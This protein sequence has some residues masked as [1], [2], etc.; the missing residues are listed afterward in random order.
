MLAQAGRSESSAIPKDYNKLCVFI[1]ENKNR[2]LSDWGLV[3]RILDAL[4]HLLT[5]AENL[6]DLHRDTSIILETIK[7]QQDALLREYQ[8]GLSI[9]QLVEQANSGALDG[10]FETVKSRSLAVRFV[11]QLSFSFKPRGQRERSTRTVYDLCASP[12]NVP[13]GTSGGDGP[14]EQAVLVQRIRDAVMKH[15]RVEYFYLVINPHS[16]SRTVHNAFNLALAI[17]MKAVS[18]ILDEGRVYATQ[19]TSGSAGVGHSA[20]HLTPQ[21]MRLIA[22]RLG[23]STAML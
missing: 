18:L 8:N 19:Y 12:A 11:D 14:D 3:A 20:L 10:F 1:A 22:E 17:R 2:I 7:L 9:E 16:Y 4:D 15:G 23:I 21:Q 6:S 5:C 13:E